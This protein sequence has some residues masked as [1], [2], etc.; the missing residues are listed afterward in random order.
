MERMT[1]KIDLEKYVEALN[2]ILGADNAY[3]RGDKDVDAIVEL[4]SIANRQQ[5]EIER[6][7]SCVKSEDEIRAIMKTQMTPMVKEIVDKQF[8][9]AVKLARAEAIKEFAEKLADVFYSHDK[10][11]TYVR[12]VVYNL[13]KEMVGEQNESLVS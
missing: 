3:F 5:A 8:D 7:N 6:L 1:D 10:G 13:V 9:I 11:D 12:E 4:I 2:N